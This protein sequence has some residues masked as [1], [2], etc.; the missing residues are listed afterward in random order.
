MRCFACHILSSTDLSNWTN[1]SSDSAQ[2]AYHVPGC[3]NGG[4][5]VHP[6]TLVLTKGSWE[7][8]L[9]I[10]EAVQQQGT[11][12]ARGVKYNYNLNNDDYL[13]C[14][15]QG[16]NPITEQ[17]NREKQVGSRNVVN[18]L[19]WLTSLLLK[20]HAPRNVKILAVIWWNF[21]ITLPDRKVCLQLLLNY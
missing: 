21:V 3:K 5:T 4:W 18:L 20:E 10:N 7:N 1:P 15:S 17:Q 16:D 9:R 8:W 14:E 6:N 12:L 13:S 2:A 19:D 11:V